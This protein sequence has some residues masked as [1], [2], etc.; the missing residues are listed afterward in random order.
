[1]QNWDFF[2]T[3]FGLWFHLGPSPKF[4]TSLEGL[5]K[6]STEP[7]LGSFQR[8]TPVYGAPDQESHQTSG[9]LGKSQLGRKAIIRSVDPFLFRF[10]CV[11]FLQ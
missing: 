1:M 10:L 8:L 4:G 6:L 9:P 5:P 2:G 7:N 3:E 11:N